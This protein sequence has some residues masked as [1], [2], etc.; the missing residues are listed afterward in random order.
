MELRNPITKIGRSSKNDMVIGRDQVDESLFNCIS[1]TQMV[2]SK[3]N[4]GV[5]VL[6]DKS[7][8]GTMVNNVKVGNGK[9]RIL[10]HN[11]VI[12]IAEFKAYV[13]MSTDKGYQKEYPTCIRS[14]YIIS[15]LLGQ[16]ACG[17]VRLVYRR[18]DLSRFAMKLID[19]R[20]LEAKG[21]T[22]SVMTEVEVLAKIDHPGFIRMKEVIDTEDVLYIVLELAEGGELFDKILDKN[23]FSEDIAKL[24]C[25]QLVSSIRYLHASE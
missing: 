21:S 9:T 11:A 15:I 1:K 4:D 5:V 20:R 23:K 12:Y 10:E 14:K 16:G 22:I 13:Y 2:I 24:H 17:T 6:T 19:K 25:F 7:T 8:N 18:S 3:R